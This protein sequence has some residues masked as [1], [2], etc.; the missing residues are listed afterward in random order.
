MN[1][2]QLIVKKNVKHKI[3]FAFLMGIVTTG[4][5]SF[6]VILTNMG[7]TETFW[8]IWLKSWSMAF[9]VVVPVILIVSPFVERFVGFLF[10]KSSEIKIGEKKDAI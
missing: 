10:K 7:F 8:Q 6:T 5:V 4:L 9:L 1:E 2:V 3:V